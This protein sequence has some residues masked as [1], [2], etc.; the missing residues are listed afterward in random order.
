MVSR[1]CPFTQKLF[2][3]MMMGDGDRLLNYSFDTVCTAPIPS[4][5]RMERV[6]NW[7]CCGDGTRITFGCKMLIRGSPMWKLV[8]AK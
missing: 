8:D 4:A 1:A 6:V 7:E 2:I 3:H 5:M